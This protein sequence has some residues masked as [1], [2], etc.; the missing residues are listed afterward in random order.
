VVFAYGLP[1]CKCFQKYDI[2]LKEAVLLAECNVSMLEDLR[3]N[4]EKEFKSI[5]KEAEVY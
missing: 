3:Q 2:D 4:I 5:Y 1:L